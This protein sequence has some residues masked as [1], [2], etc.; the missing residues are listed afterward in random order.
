MIPLVLHP[1]RRL[2]CS[3][4]QVGIGSHM[5]K[6]IPKY[7][8]I[9]SQSTLMGYNIAMKRESLLG[10]NLAQLTPQLTTLRLTLL[11]A[12]RSRMLAPRNGYHP[13]RLVATTR[14]DF[15]LQVI[16]RRVGLRS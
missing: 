10:K 14:F 2:D 8:Y 9:C 15:Q 11:S 12:E 3:D 13:V 4:K 7:Q 1:D 16:A 5:W 6:W